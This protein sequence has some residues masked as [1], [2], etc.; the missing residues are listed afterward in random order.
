VKVPAARKMSTA[1]ASI[2]ESAGGS[3]EES[4]TA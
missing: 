2:V 3:A 4:A 1:L